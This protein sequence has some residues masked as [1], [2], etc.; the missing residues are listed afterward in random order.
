VLPKRGGFG[1][2]GVEPG[3][4]CEVHVAVPEA[5]DD[6]FSRA[7]DDPSGVRDLHARP[8]ADGGDLAEGGEYNRVRNG[9]RRRRRVYGAANKGKVVRRGSGPQGKEEDEDQRGEGKQASLS[10]G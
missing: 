3:I 9:G 8:R 7:I 10:H 4:L 1:V 6:D 5:G 2:C